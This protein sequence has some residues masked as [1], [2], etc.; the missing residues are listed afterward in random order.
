MGDDSITSERH[1][2]EN[3]SLSP[4]VKHV[5][6]RVHP[7]WPGKLE[8]E[9]P[10]QPRPLW[11]RRIHVVTP[12][13]LLEFFGPARRG[14]FRNRSSCSAFTITAFFVHGPLLDC[15]ASD[16]SAMPVF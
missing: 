14:T 12:L 6:V 13:R 15:V 9:S 8:S 5:T 16:A 1:G 11:T 7:H 2:R 4:L 3:D 10:R